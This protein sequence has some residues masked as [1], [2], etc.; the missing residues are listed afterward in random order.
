MT[1]R[2]RGLGEWG[3]EMLG[4]LIPRKTRQREAVTIT[5]HQSLLR[6]MGILGAVIEAITYTKFPECAILAGSDDNPPTANPAIHGLF[7]RRNSIAATHGN[8]LTAWYNC[9]CHGEPARA[10]SERRIKRSPLRD[11]AGM[12]RSF[13]YAA[14]A[15]L[16]RHQQMRSED[17]PILE[18]WAEAWYRYVSGAVYE[19][20]YE[21]D[22]RPGWVRI[23][24][25]GIRGTLQGFS[26]D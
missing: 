11:V 2:G 15:V 14:Y 21:L 25:R 1:A 7:Y 22:N 20:G 6:V 8:R 19:L 5:A 18:E 10:M 26:A 9:K 17:V 3:R 24:L 13:H 12:I 4:T 16:F 23:P